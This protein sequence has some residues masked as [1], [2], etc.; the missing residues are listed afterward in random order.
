M[1]NIL[2]EEKLSTYTIYLYIE[3]FKKNE[4]ILIKFVES[5]RSL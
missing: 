5:Q 1:L 2:V 3:E 4:I